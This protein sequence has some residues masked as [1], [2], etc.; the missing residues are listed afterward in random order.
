MNEF[1][2]SSKIDLRYSD[3]F[4]A[5]RI[6]DCSL[7]KS[8]SF[9]KL[10]RE[11]AERLIQRIRHV[12]KMTWRQLS[13]LS[14]EDGITTEK[15]SSESYSLIDQQNTQAEKLFEKYYFHLRIEKVGLFRIFGYQCGVFF[16]ITH[17]DYQG[18][19]HHG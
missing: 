5:F 10:T 3:E 9:Y 19:I 16:C 12:E 18:K 6:S 13:G 7:D 15:P 1:E 11:Q 4:V 8:Y 2:A 17:I 14:R